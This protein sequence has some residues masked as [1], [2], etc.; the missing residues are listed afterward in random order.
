MCPRTFQRCNRFPVSVDLRAR[1]PGSAGTARPSPA[2]TCSPRRCR[3]R[4][5][6]SGAPGPSPRPCAGRR[7]RTSCPGRRCCCRVAAQPVLHF[8]RD[9]DLHTKAV[10]GFVAVIVVGSCFRTNGPTCVGDSCP[11]R[12]ARDKTYPHGAVSASRPPARGCGSGPSRPSPIFQLGRPPSTPRS[13]P[14][15]PCVCPCRSRM[16]TRTLVVPPTPGP[17]SSLV[18]VRSA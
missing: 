10:V 12:E 11:R 4:P 9:H 14:P 13:G 18:V 3:R 6:P 15:C 5:S 16:P 8:L 1:A 2:S 17:C 7:P